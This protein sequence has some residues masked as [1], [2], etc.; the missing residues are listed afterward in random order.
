MFELGDC[1]GTV[2]PK[3]PRGFRVTGHE[4]LLYGNC[5]RCTETPAKVRGRIRR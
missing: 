3:P 1:A 4:L 2:L 5:A